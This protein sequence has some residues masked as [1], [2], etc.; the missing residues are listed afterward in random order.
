MLIIITV[1]RRATQER[2]LISKM[3]REDLE[4]K[5]LKN[6]DENIVLKKYARKQEDRIKKMATKL[7]KLVNDK[8][9]SVNQSDFTV[10]ASSGKRVRDVDTEEYLTELQAKCADL[11]MHNK[12]LK[13]NLQTCKIQLQTLQ[14]GKN[15]VAAVY[16]NVTSRIDTGRPK[17]S[18][19]LVK[20][21]RTVATNQAN[22]NS[23]R[24]FTTPRFS[25]GASTHSI[26]RQVVHELEAENQELRGRIDE[27]E[28]HIE[29]LN[30]EVGNQKRLIEQ[31]A[32]EVGRLK[33]QAA[34]E[35]MIGVQVSI[36][37]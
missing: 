31:K 9:K 28:A 26:D 37:Y 36:L 14:N 15:S 22:F 34:K 33:G 1:D 8:K 29:V 17:T 11:E 16:S 23:T 21:I 20:N 27:Y 32:E 30:G 7:I 6:Y 19:N 24:S 13:E 2:L 5:Y 3:S 25:A 4:D 35:Q 12:R 10:Q 18:S